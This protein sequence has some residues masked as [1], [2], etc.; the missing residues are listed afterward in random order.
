MFK[1]EY[2]QQKQLVE[3]SNQIRRN[4]TKLRKLGFDSEYDGD[5]DQPFFDMEVDISDQNNKWYQIYESESKS[6]NTL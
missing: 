6:Q 3:L 4:I 2:Y 1:N 5:I